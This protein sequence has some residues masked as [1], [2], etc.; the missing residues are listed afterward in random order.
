MGDLLQTTCSK[1]HFGQ[2][3]ML[4]LQRTVKM[5]LQFGRHSIYIFIGSYYGYIIPDVIQCI[6]NSALLCRFSMNITRC[7]TS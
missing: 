1:I 5:P 7:Q 2:P 4:Y 6:F 3:I